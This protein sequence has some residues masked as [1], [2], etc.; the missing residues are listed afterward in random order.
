MEILLERAGLKKTDTSLQALLSGDE[1]QWARLEQTAKKTGDT[2]QLLDIYQ[3]FYGLPNTEATIDTKMRLRDL[4]I[5]T[6]STVQ[7]K[8]F[9]DDFARSSLYDSWSAETIGTGSVST[10]LHEKLQEKLQNYIQQGANRALID[11]LERAAKQERLQKINSIL[12]DAK[13]GILNTLG[14]RNLLEEAKKDVNL[15][16]LKQA[17][18]TATE[19]RES[20]VDGIKKLTQ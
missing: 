12:E 16:G 4:I 13:Q 14:K 15:D 8:N 11:A 6:A 17:N 10:I 2:A 9:L 1:A 3:A 19:V 5:E 7:K 18:D 20:I